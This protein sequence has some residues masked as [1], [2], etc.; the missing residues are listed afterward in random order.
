MNV[1]MKATEKG[2]EEKGKEERSE[3]SPDCE[4]L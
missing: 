3:L 4:L 1:Y 2:Q